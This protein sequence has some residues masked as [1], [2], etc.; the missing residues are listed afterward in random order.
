MERPV[1]GRL[2][3]AT[4]ALVAL[5]LLVAAFTVGRPAPLPAPALPPSFDEAAARQ[6]AFSFAR[7]YPA[8]DPGGANAAEAA[9][10]VGSQLEAYGFTVTEQAFEADI[11]GKGRVR[12]V[13]L[14][15]GA[16][17]TDAGS[18][19]DAIVVM[20]HR[21]NSGLSPGRNDNASGTAAL[22]ELARNLSAVSLNHRI[23][24]VSTDGGSFGNL[25]AARLAGDPEFRRNVIAVV[26]LDSIAGHG[27]VRLQFAG[28]TPRSP[29]GELLSTADA[30]VL[31]QTG[32]R[33]THPDALGQL[34]DLAFPFSFYDQG[35]F[36]GAGISG[37]TLTTAGDRPPTPATDTEA[38]FDATR[39]GA[40][41][42]S[43]QSLIGSLDAAAEV[44]QGTESYV[45]L[46]GRFVRGLAV[47][48]LLIVAMLPP[49]LATLDL[50]VRLRRRG[51]SLGPAFRS[52]ASRLL[53]WGWA[54]LMAAVFSLFGLFPNGDDRPLSPDTAPAQDWP[55][56][57]LLAF[58]VI[59]SIGWFA[60]RPRLI[61]TR[62]IEREEELAG[63]VAVMVALAAV[64]I[65][66]AATNPFT[67]VFVL[68]SLHAWLWIPH[69]RDSALGL[70]L[71][72]YAVGFAGLVLL[73]VSFA[74]RF[75]LGFDA[76]WY[77]AT[78]FSVGYAPLVLFI[79]FLG[80]GAAAGQALAILLGRYSP[81]PPPEERPERGP[82]R[83]TVRRLELARRARR[84][85]RSIERQEADLA[86]GGEL[87]VATRD[88]DE[89]VGLRGGHDHV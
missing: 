67:L 52:Y 63:H 22:I 41:G 70:R 20:A 21:D 65:L 47:T 60:A 77:V 82:V 86:A 26:D 36:V 43:A 68:P 11:P 16:P 83:E 19:S 30:A 81:Y 14:V 80:W 56:W 31:G 35:P 6:V 72:L 46:G 3:R 15:A 64:S 89:R 2:Y 7:D 85:A 8:R 45:Y 24:F 84:A 23:L 74:V 66:L 12:L 71:T 25:G 18:S 5:P 9:A 75:G 37:V 62:V 28:D 32:S 88:V 79:A 59:A 39:L 61:P 53:V 69:A 34:V 87:T 51:I 13:N 55:F 33:P 4:W 17:V 76:P 42:R 78:L 44:A 38:A 73:F 48:F 58:G 54:G 1:S 27:R 40:V 10:W 49:L 29:A 57:L 50:L